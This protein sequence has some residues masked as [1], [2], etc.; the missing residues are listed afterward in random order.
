HPD[1]VDGLRKRI[2]RPDTIGEKELQHRAEDFFRVFS[3]GDSFRRDL[4]PFE[5]LDQAN[6]L[7]VFSRKPLVCLRANECERSQP[8]QALDWLPRGRAELVSGQRPNGVWS[9]D[10]APA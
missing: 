2:R 5:E 7:N 9:H 4:A 8:A 6:A 10:V 3:S 1:D